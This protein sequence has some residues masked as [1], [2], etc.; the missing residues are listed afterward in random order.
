MAQQDPGRAGAPGQE[1]SSGSG[2]HEAR[3]P[4]SRSGN[5]HRRTARDDRRITAQREH[6]AGPAAG[7]GD[8]R[9]MEAN[10]AAVAANRAYRAGDLD[11][12]RQLIDQAAALDPSRAEL[13]QQHREQIAAR[14]LILD[15]RA[16]HAEGDHQRA[17]KLLGD[18]RQLDPRMPAIWDGDL[19]ATACWAGLPH[20]R[21]RSPGARP[22]PALHGQPAG[23]LGQRG[24]ATTGKLYA[25][26]PGPIATILAIV[27]SRSH[28]QQ[29]ESSPAADSG[30]SSAPPSG[31]V[32]A[33]PQL[34]PGTAA[35]HAD[36]SGQ[37][38]ATDPARWPVPDSHATGQNLW[39][40]EQARPESGTGQPSSGK[41]HQ[42]GT[43]SG[44]EPVS[45]RNPHKPTSPEADWRDQIL[46]QARQPE[47][48]SPSWP[49]SPVLRRMPEP[50]APD[51]GL[52]PGR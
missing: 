19:D 37:A 24:R 48:P 7:P 34:G 28:R 3:R 41:Q 38:A 32:P 2:R 51:V 49:C 27:P 20:P 14:R 25:G 23:G 44:T 26:Q 1:A 17:D 5:G 9:R 39:P 50:G 18:A 16:A 15:A 12:A 35:H 4:S 33:G 29:P 36:I 52:E 42:P 45:S 22:A 43:A 6:A 8:S 47:H 13:W 46:H 40:E 21:T 30:S 10:R 11:Q 31:A